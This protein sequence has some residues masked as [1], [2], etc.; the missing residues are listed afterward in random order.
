MGLL[1]VEGQD[2]EAALRCRSALIQTH[3]E[4][5]SSQILL[6]VWTRDSGYFHGAVPKAL[7][8]PDVIE[9]ILGEAVTNRCT[10]VTQLRFTFYTH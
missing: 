1:T 7:K 10:Q 2:S 3:T 8:R 4:L 6:A 9:L 5:L